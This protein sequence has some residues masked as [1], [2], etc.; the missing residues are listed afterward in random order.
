VSIGLSYWETDTHQYPQQPPLYQLMF[1]FATRER[2]Q[3]GV[4]CAGCPQLFVRTWPNWHSAQ[5]LRCITCMVALVLPYRKSGRSGLAQCRSRQPWQQL[6]QQ[7][8]LVSSFVLVTALA[9][10]STIVTSTVVPASSLLQLATQ[11]VARGDSTTLYY[12][13]YICSSTTGT[14][15]WYLYGCRLVVVPV[16]VPVPEMD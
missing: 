4:P 15:G 10:S 12:Y 14:T 6:K 1:V 11:V 7:L 9:S 8:K 2:I 13:Q 3:T 5:Q 16:L